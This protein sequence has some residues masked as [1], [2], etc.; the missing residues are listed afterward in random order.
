MEYLILSM[1]P[2]LGGMLVFLMPIEVA[3]LT[4]GRS[5]EVT[6]VRLCSCMNSDVNS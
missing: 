1:F 2:C 3:A 5:T 4:E 6:F